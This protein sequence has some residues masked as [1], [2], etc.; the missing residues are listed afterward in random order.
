MRKVLTVVLGLA[1]AGFV[2]ALDAVLMRGRPKESAME[3]VQ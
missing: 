3:G 1:M 2:S